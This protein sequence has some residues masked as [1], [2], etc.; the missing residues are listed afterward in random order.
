[1]NRQCISIFG[2]V[3]CICL[4]IGIISSYWPIALII[5]ISFIIYGVNKKNSLNKNSLNETDLILSAGVYVGGR[6]I[7]IGIYDLRVASGNGI[8][9]FDGENKFHE[10][11]SYDD[12]NSYNNIEISDGFI[13]KINVGIK[14]K[15]H[16]YRDFMNVGK[17]QDKEAEKDTL[18]L[19]AMDGHSFE[20][21]CADVLRKNGYSNVKVT[22]GSGDQG[23]DILAERDNIKYAIQ[24][25]HYSQP[26]GNKAVQEIYTGMRFHHC[27]VGIIMTNNY[28]TKSAKELAKENGVVLWDK[29]YLT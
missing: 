28:Y 7:D 10:F 13:L 24:C 23:V 3:I 14:I 9:E 25:K 19:D 12:G 17:I 11:L 18:R 27:H 16:N 29:D 1:M 6:D 5:I 20:Y 8:V 15:L 26:V 4:V 21:F 22:Q 2:I